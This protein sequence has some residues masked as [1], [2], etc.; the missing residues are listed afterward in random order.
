MELLP[1]AGTKIG[2]KCIM[3]GQKLWGIL[4]DPN[5]PINHDSQ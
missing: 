5:K 3:I 4:G 2:I 1:N